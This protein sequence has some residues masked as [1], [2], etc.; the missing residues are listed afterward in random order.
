MKFSRNDELGRWEGTMELQ[1][2]QVKL[3][4]DCSCPEPALAALA[5]RTRGRLTEARCRIETNLVRSLHGLYNSQW[6]RPD[7]GFP[8]LSEGDFLKKI[9]LDAVE[10]MEEEAISMYFS[11]SGLFAGHCVELL[12]DSTGKLYQATLIG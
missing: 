6:A 11:D 12:W 1:G 10:V 8:E 9:V 2:H 3:S 4:I 5:E 7:D